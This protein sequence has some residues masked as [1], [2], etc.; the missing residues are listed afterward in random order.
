[1]DWDDCS[2]D[3]DWFCAWEA[4]CSTLD[5]SSSTDALVSSRVAAWLCALEASCR[6]L[7]GDLGARAG[8]RVRGPADL[9]YHA[10]KL[11]DHLVDS[12]REAPQLIA[13]LELDGAAEIPARNALR[14]QGRSAPGACFSMNLLIRY[15]AR[16]RIAITERVIRIVE[17]SSDLSCALIEASE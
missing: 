10:A 1:M 3:A 17:M 6:E 11:G 7:V 2:T 13:G 16:A 15:V 9:P 4:T 8:Q 5:V 14:R 12:V